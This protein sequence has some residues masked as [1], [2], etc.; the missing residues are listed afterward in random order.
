MGW[1]ARARPVPRHARVVRWVWCLAVC[2]A[3][4]L[5]AAAPAIAVEAVKGEVSVTTAGGYARI[6]F[7]LAES[8][9]SEVR[10]SNGVLVIAFKRPVDVLVDR[11]NVNA[12]DY[13]SAARLDPDGMG[14][15]LAL[16]QKVTVNA[17][18]A[19]EQL[20]V[21]LLPDSWTALPPGLPTNVVE[22]L[23]RRARDAEKKVR[24]QRALE[25]QKK[26]T[27]IRVRVAE[28]PTFTRYIFDLPEFINVSADRAKEKLTL[29]FGAPLEFDLAAAKAAMPPL[30]ASIETEGDGESTSVQFVFDGPVDLR[31]FREDNTYVMDVVI[32]EGQKGSAQSGKPADVAEFIARQA[33][34]R[35]TE[36]GE[37]PATAPVKA[38]ETDN[39]AA[40]APMNPPPSTEV[41]V[42][43]GANADHETRPAPASEVA[44]EQQRPRAPPAASAAPAPSAQL[45][46]EPSP[47]APES[48][49]APVAKTAV[50]TQQQP[51]A[52]P[53]PA[54]VQSPEAAPPTRDP[55][56]PLAVELRRQ[57]DSLRLTFPFAAPTPAAV[58]R[59]AD[60][61]WLV[62]DSA[63]EL[64]LAPLLAEPSHMI[65]SASVAR[66][67]EG[68]AVRLKLARPRLTS[69]TAQRAAWTLVVGDVAID[70]TQPLALQ[71]NFVGPN[72]ASVTIPFDDPGHL[73]R[74]SDPDAGDTLVAV[75]A[76]GPARGF[77]K[78]QR[79]L[80]FN[81]LASTQGVVVQPIADD[82]QMDFAADKIVV[83]RPG[84]LTLST[85]IQSSGRATGPQPATFDAQLWGFDRQGDYNQRQTQLLRIAAASPEPKK[86]PARLD[87]ARF[88]LAREMYAEAKAV[89]DVLLADRPPSSEDTSAL[90]LHAVANIGLN[91]PEAAVKDLA[92][93][94][95]GSQHD[96]PLWRAF[97][98]AKEGKWPE[99]RE[100]F[101]GVGVGI[102]TLPIELQ[103]VSLVEAV[104][105]F[106]EVRDFAGA[107][108][109]LNEFDTIGVPRE[110]EPTIAV[111]T[112]RLAEGLGR[113]DDALAAY[114][115]AADSADRPQAA[116]GRLRE[117]MLRHRNGDLDSAAM[118]T[119]LE[120][121]TSTWRG[122][123]TEIE[124]LQALGHLYT[125]EQR[126]RDAFHVMRAALQGHPNSDM[127]RR[128][129]DEAAA[130][131]DSL[132]LAG[133]GDAMPAVE[134]LSLFYDFRELTAIGRRGDE[135]I[136][137]LA[138]RLVSVDLLDQAAELLQHQVDHRLQGAARGR[139]AA[140]L[141]VVYL[142]NR[143]PDR[144]LA[145]LRAT[146]A[147]N[148]GNEL[149]N[150]R[151]LL[152]GRALSD[153]GRHEL[154]LDI[155]SHVGLREAIRL[156]S[157]IYWA[158]HRY[159]E[160]AEQIELLYGDRFKDWQ[161]LNELE[162]GDIL[163]AA[164]GYALSDDQLGLDR[165]REKYAA[166]IADGRDRHAF[167]V[168]SGPPGPAGAEFREIAKTIAAVDTLGGFLRDMRARYPETGAFAPAASAPAASMPA[169]NPGTAAP[170]AN[171][172]QLKGPKADPM[173][174]GS[175]TLR[176]KN[177]RTAAR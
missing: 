60:T 105:S 22:D 26:R 70:P 100:A 122:D 71:R 116:Q 49:G 11:I 95:V 156:R 160:S 35:A 92:N 157:D 10:A 16:A 115:A 93:P 150:E 81:V 1:P 82:L 106:I 29:F 171:G 121:L 40:K 47:A 162:R 45:V 74:L 79:F 46:G 18:S 169:G 37:A 65:L 80:E 88:Y 103:R 102:A 52:R 19:A 5:F 161:P 172:A 24:L 101:K 73:H 59:R 119:Q 133:K 120:T 32:P 91:R 23:A 21:D 7:R 3:A 44:P 75:T 77:L 175:V 89:L 67:G 96:A 83:G 130:T 170:P 56:A 112:G 138:D 124:A 143:K 158:A 66:S 128:I 25:L 86:A 61:L 176:A 84:G 126:Y 39:P 6:I 30:L 109:E 62:F 137:R 36:R 125:E 139:V 108:N 132:F 94:L 68:Q 153:I 173:P 4:V 43:P 27:P 48:A 64:D 174:T 163:R 15:R 144:A 168:V 151:L 159:R 111:L 53:Q 114:R 118:V 20:F 110:L 136:R 140:R 51:A 113:T 97:A 76:L 8:V 50:E 135:M 146:H 141:A 28:Q 12:P 57:G 41:R 129:Q 104:R 69:L 177:K 149:R 33:S 9:E 131:F 165:F 134:A 2:L 167:E 58:F 90:V 127:T 14:I 34:K 117:L 31:T 147:A 142:M 98:L 38:P 13:V 123:Q 99:A 87:L 42:G 63:T 145:T 164:L 85:G 148:G 17:T 166:K 155:I 78:E 55:N 154:A 72:R 54:P 152:E 107:A